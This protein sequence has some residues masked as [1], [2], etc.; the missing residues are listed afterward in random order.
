MSL[1]DKDA[2]KIIELVLGMSNNEKVDEETINVVSE[3]IETILKISPDNVKD[4]VLVSEIDGIMTKLNETFNT[5]K[6]KP[7]NTP[8]IKFLDNLNLKINEIKHCKYLTKT[9]KESEES[10]ESEAPAVTKVVEDVVPEASEASEA[11]AVTKVDEVVLPVAS[12]ASEASEEPAVTEVDEIDE[13]DELHIV[14]NILFDKGI[15]KGG[16]SK[17]KR[18]TKTKTKRKKRKRSKIYRRTKNK[19]KR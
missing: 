2:I 4:T 6:G 13:S 15:V 5:L 9:S 11:S 8:T 17:S 14:M 10:A 1:F 18:N 3:Y 19:H 12:E 7:N 16:G